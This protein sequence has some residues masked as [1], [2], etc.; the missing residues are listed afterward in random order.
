MTRFLVVRHAESDKTL[1]KIHGGSG[2]TITEQG[3]KDIEKLA[4]FINEALANRVRSARIYASFVPQVR[5]TAEMLSQTTSIPVEL[6]ENLK[7]INMGV[8]DGLSDEDASARYPEAMQRLKMWREGLLSVEEIKIPGAE[9]LSRFVERVAEVI[10]RGLE[11]DDEL[12]IF[13]VTR[14]VG[15]A[16]LNTLLSESTLAGKPYT[17]FRLDPCSATL[18]EASTIG[19]GNLLYLNQT[20]FLGRPITYPD[21]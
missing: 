16:I 3:Q 21:D 1:R 8:I 6:Y 12:R 13:I 18:V 11:N 9:P 15:I 7:N 20:G 4:G 14:S 17:R 5:L 10:K 2:T 19:K